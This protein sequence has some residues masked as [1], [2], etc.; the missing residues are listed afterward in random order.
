M[1]TNIL[2]RTLAGVLAILCVAGSLPAN[3]D[4]GGLFD[5]A[6]VAK[7]QL[8]N[9]TFLGATVNATTNEVTFTDETCNVYTPVT[10][11]TDHVTWGNSTTPT[12]YVVSGN[13]D[14]TSRITVT[15]EVNLI[16]K[17]GAKL[18]A[19]EG[20][21]VAKESDSVINTLNIFGQAAGT[22]AL[23]ATGADSSAGIGGVAHGAVGT[24]T[25][26]GGQV[27]ATGS[28]DAAG[29]GGGYEG[30]GGTVT[31]NGGQVTATGSDG[32]AG[33]GGGED[34]A[35]GTVTINGGQVTATGSDYAAGIGGGH[36]RQ[37]GTVIVNGGNVTAV[38]G[39]YAAGIGGGYNGA[40]GSVTINGGQVTATGG[41]YSVGIGKRE[42]AP[43]NGALTISDSL[44]LQSKSGN[45]WSNVSNTGTAQEPDYERSREMRTA[46]KLVAGQYIAVGDIVNVYRSKVDIETSDYYLMYITDEISQ[47]ESFYSK[48]IPSGFFGNYKLSTI[49]GY[50]SINK[51]YRVTMSN[52]DTDNNDNSIEV[53]ISSESELTPAPTG[54]WVTGGMGTSADPFIFS[55]D[56]PAIITSEPAAK[57]LTYTGSAQ[58]L[59]TAGTANENS[60]MQY[61]L[62]NVIELNADTTLNIDNV[63]VGYVYHPTNSA[64]ITLPNDYTG[65]LT[66]SVDG[67]KYTCEPL[68]NQSIT[69][70][71]TQLKNTGFTS[72]DSLRVTKVDT[73][74]K[75]IYFDGVKVADYA[76]CWSTAI[77]ETTN[78][79]DYTV[80]YKAVRASD[81]TESVIGSVDVTIGKADLNPTAE[82]LPT[83][84]TGLIY[85]GTAH[86][87]VNAPTTAPTGGT[88]KY[89]DKL[90]HTGTCDIKVGDI[91]NPIDEQGIFF[92]EKYM[93]YILQYTDIQGNLRTITP[94]A[95]G[96]LNI[97]KKENG[98]SYG[99]GDII[100]A[101]PSPKDALKITAID[102]NSQAITAVLVSSA[103]E[104]WSTE[105]P[106]GTD[107][108]SYTIEYKFIGDANHNDY[109]PAEPLS[110]TIAK[111]DPLKTAPTS[112]NPTYYSSAVQL[113]NAGTVETGCKI[114]Y[115]LGTDATTAPTNGWETDVTKITANQ[116]GTFYVWYKATGDDVNYADA[117]PQCIT[118]KVMQAQLWTIEMPDYVYDGTAHDPIINGTTY[119]DLT[120]TY[121]TSAGVML[122]EAPTEP[123]DYLIWV[124]AAGDDTH[125]SKLE[126]AYYT[127]KSAKFA[128]GNTVSFKEKVE[129]NFLVEATDAETV[130]GAYVVFTYDHYGE[131]MTVKKA[132]DKSDK[133]GKYYR[134]RLP[135]TASEMA[136]DIKAELYLP[137]LDK[138]VD[139]KTRSIKDYAEAAIKSNL[140][141]AEVLKAMLNYG[142]YTQTALGNN[143]TLL[144]NSGEGIAVDVSAVS[145]KSATTFVRPTATAAKVTYKGSTAMTTSDLY[146]RHYFTVDSSLTG[147]ELNAV[148]IMVG[149]KTAAL[150]D[151][152]KNNTG[153]YYDVA[154]QLAY[155]LDKENDRIVVYGFA[156][157][158][159][160]DSPNAI[161]IENYNVIDYC[162]AVA[163][164]DKQTTAAKNMAKALYSYYKAAKAYVDSRA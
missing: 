150:K 162:E 139:T 117:A 2:K 144:A 69:E 15:G 105:I 46:K 101:F 142:G 75:K 36:G 71:L 161:S 98:L 22:G 8:D 110:V 49:S 10:S 95:G 132:I 125:P 48:I 129:F 131:K 126:S 148:K 118:V 20:I 63:K 3:V 158:E 57:G 154:P 56:A 143:T 68:E 66:I 64:N 79:G 52:A 108:R 130:E 134:V 106:Q 70:L 4:G 76:N 136:I 145:P 33:I 122:S 92:S 84:K 115:A 133:N 26:N 51:Q 35:G 59:V 13:V 32:A 147:R 18:T 12:W 112:K 40:G 29:I 157:A 77:P 78:A 135:L 149:E 91:L 44:V 1:K 107:A 114:E 27:T 34:G 93:N 94:A 153:Y 25:I 65:R 119:G 146:V 140:D 85:D 137:T 89:N 156:G 21:T 111:G 17:D 96:V 9:V 159:T 104:G 73:Q 102:N 103:T 39:C 87:L 67:G 127:I 14:I 72:A 6:I 55:L 16:L 43:D 113:I 54:F 163:N 124:S 128:A 120:Y 74:E 30:A 5:T 60:Q 88:L 24:V 80:Y 62:S 90:V 123:G 19:S 86:Q 31:I 155:E 81:S 160:A 42:G 61:S 50:D 41:Q 97:C 58:A 141:G 23:I 28:D 82:N 37:G 38:G 138:P 53:P 45:T 11:S 151:L 83:A 121:L 99:I 100:V 164:S 152:P 7:A 116:T 47:S 109:V